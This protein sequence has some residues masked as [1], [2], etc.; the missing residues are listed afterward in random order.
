MIGPAIVVHGDVARPESKGADAIAGLGG[1]VCI[2]GNGHVA[3]HGSVRRVV[4][5]PALVTCQDAGRLAV[6]PPPVVISAVPDLIVPFAVTVMLLSADAAIAVAWS[7][8]TIPAL[9]SP[10]KSTVSTM[11]PVA[12]ESRARQSPQAHGPNSV[13]CGAGNRDVTGPTL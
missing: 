1:N 7:T 4:A 5:R 3:K 2:V 8:T 13:K 12:I 6:G 9:P 11:S 10:P